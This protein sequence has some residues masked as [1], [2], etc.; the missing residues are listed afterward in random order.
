MRTTLKH[1]LAAFV[2]VSA[3][4]TLPLTAQAADNT[5]TG[6][7]TGSNANSNSTSGTVGTYV[8][9]ATV[10]TRVKAKFAE[11][12]S[13]GAMSIGVETVQGVVQL[14]GFAK[15]GTE[16]SQAERLVRGTPGVKSIRNDIIV[17]PAP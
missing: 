15:S 8:D 4:A 2:A 13:V 5:G 3:A 12:K 14:S 6:M 16:K 7:A 1:A 17:R 10:T 9:D 11:D